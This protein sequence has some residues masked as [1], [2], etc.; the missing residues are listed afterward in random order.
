VQKVN[1][2]VNMKN[3]L[4]NS[5]SPFYKE[6]KLENPC[7]IQSPYPLLLGGEL[8]N[9]LSISFVRALRFT[10]NPLVPFS[11]GELRGNY[12]L[13]NKQNIILSY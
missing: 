5:F 6:D 1:S 7:F 13:T 3:K 8:R 9:K 11:K 12:F 10:F 4:F 2:D